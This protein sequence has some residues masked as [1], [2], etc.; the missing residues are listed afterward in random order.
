MLT[1]FVGQTTLLAHM[2][3]IVVKHCSSNNPVTTCEIFTFEVDVHFLAFNLLRKH[4]IWTTYLDFSKNIDTLN[5][6]SC[7]YK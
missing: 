5:K 4:D 1:N 3:T 7:G 2:I 6:S